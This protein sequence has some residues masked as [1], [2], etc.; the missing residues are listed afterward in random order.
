[1]KWRAAIVIA[2]AVVVQAALRVVWP[3]SVY[4][5]LPLIAVVYFA[6]RRD[7]VQA[8]LIGWAAGFAADA[9]SRGLLGAGG[10]S[11]TVVAYVIAVLGTRVVLDNP[12]VRILVLAGA[13]ALDA[14]VY[15]LLHELFNQTLPYPFVET[16]A[17]K[18]IAT[19]VGGTLLILLYDYNFGEKAQRRRQFAFRRRVARR[20]PGR[21]LR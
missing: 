6:L 12:V 15:V 10:F 16:L 17:F 5:D 2:L 18:L 7:P 3:S 1:M 4:L 11:K 14:I 13:T 8:V 9:L 20:A 21:R 19:T